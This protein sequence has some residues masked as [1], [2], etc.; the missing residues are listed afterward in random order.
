VIAM[1]AVLAIIAIVVMIVPA[2]AT[3]VARSVVNN[4][5]RSPSSGSIDQSLVEARLGRIEEAIDAMALQI[6]RLSE[7]QRA[8]LGPVSDASRLEEADRTRTETPT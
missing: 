6:E 2:I 1:L 7:H 3:T 5:D 4:L 8:L